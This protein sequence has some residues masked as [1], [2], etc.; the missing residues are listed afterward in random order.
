MKFLSVEFPPDISQELLAL[1]L[2]LSIVLAIHCT[3]ILL[4]VGHIQYPLW[5]LRL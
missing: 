1:V 4:V 3:G 5:S 2:A